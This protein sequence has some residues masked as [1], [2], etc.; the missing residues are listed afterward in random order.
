MAKEFLADYVRVCIP[1]AD[2]NQIVD[3]IENMCGCSS[4]EIE[5]LQNAEVEDE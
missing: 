5:I 4:N 3:D 2:W 1:R